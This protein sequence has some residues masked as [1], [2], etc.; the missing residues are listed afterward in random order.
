MQDSTAIPGPSF[1]K[2]TT[3]L[4]QR[5]SPSVK[6]NSRAHGSVPRMFGNDQIGATSVQMD[7][8]SYDVHK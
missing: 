7:A 6:L 4:A 2:D 5:Q 1:F 8:L 3:D